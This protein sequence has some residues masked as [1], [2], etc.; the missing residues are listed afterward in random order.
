[1]SQIG[2][3]DSENRVEDQAESRRLDLSITGMTCAACAARIEGAL[4]RKS[5]IKDA[6]VNLAAETARVDY[7]PA[8]IRPSEIRKAVEEAGYG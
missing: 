2:E 8:L 5:G 3:N 1:M 6:A 7:D 4:R